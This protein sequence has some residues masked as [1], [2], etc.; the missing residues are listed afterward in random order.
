[1][2]KAHILVVDD[3]PDLLR[4]VRRTLELEGYDAVGAPDGKTALALFEQRQP[5]LAIL[6]IMMPD[7][8]GY[9][10]LQQIR[11]RSNIPV[12]M[13]TAIQEED[14]VR[15]AFGLGADDYVRKPFR[16]HELLARVKAK[17]RRSARKAR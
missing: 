13:L 8:D 10:V 6:D 1:M 12:I 16:T 2:K 3:N 4:I 11:Q 15:T 5:D 7:M 14:S 9:Q 17:L